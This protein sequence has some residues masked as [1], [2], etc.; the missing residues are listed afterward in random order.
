MTLLLDTNILTRA[1]QPSHPMHQ[2]ALDAVTTL[3]AEGEEL[4]VVPQNLIE[5]WVVATRPRAVN[6]LEMKTSHAAIELA[7]IKSLFRLLPDTPSVFA[8]WE[9]LVLLHSVSGKKAHD[10]RIVAAMKTYSVTTLLTFNTSDFRR[11][12]G[13][14]TVDPGDVR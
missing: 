13:I 1:A 12:P 2:G 14:I 4:C 11:Y 8:E 6:G 7:R 3:R 10:A 5:F 9:K